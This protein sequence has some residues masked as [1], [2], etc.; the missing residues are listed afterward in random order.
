MLVDFQ[1]ALNTLATA[2]KPKVDPAVAQALSDDA[3]GVSV[4][5][6]EIGTA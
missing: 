6:D 4:C 5:I 1:S 3:Q 2:P